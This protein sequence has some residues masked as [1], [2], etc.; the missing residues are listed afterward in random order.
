MSE[1]YD[2]RDILK[3]CN[4]VMI[5]TNEM[6]ASLQ[7]VVGGG[8][9]KEGSLIT[10]RKHIQDNISQDAESLMKEIRA[11]VEAIRKECNERIKDAEEAAKLIN[12]VE[13]GRLEG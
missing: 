13:S 9:V 2:P 5:A 11:R 6:E 8:D 4:K 10:Y 12:I 1:L 3:M 7:K